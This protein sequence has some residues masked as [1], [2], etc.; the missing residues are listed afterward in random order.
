MTVKADL[1]EEFEW[2]RDER[3]EDFERLI[4]VGDLLALLA[5][6]EQAEAQ[7]ALREEPPVLLAKLEQAER[8]R[9]EWEARWT[10]VV[11][12]QLAEMA[13]TARAQAAAPEYDEEAISGL[14]WQLADATLAVEQEQKP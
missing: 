2:I 13:R 14:L 4:R 7:L 6:L 12:D 8:E 10:R 1:R 5:E 11:K 9:D 3:G